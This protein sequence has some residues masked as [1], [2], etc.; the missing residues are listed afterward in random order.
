MPHFSGNVYTP[1]TCIAMLDSPPKTENTR[2]C[3]NIP[4]RGYE[5]SISMDARHGT[6]DLSRSELCIFDR[7]G[8]DM[9]ELVMPE[10]GGR[11]I[12]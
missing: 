6:D 9:T 3:T 7:R 10:H 12:A 1:C 4:Y 11:V 2:V 5:I 8:I